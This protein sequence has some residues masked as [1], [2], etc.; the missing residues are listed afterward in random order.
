MTRSSRHPASNPALE[1]FTLIELL[2]FVVLVSFVV[3]GVHFLGWLRGTIV[4]F[5]GFIFA[6]SALALVRDG[7]EGIPRL[8]KCRNGC[9]RGPG[10]LFG[11][12]QY[13]EVKF[14]EEYYRV[15]CCGI[16]HK[17]R[18]KRFVV[19]NDDGT[20]VPHLIWRP[21]KGWFPD[22]GGISQPN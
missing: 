22:S 16:R 13:G 9:C 17:R 18:G 19:V 21:F 10:F 12:G 20:E 8:P 1:G 3:V 2:A 7:F 14:G 6:G 11:H 5:A 15:C 4:G